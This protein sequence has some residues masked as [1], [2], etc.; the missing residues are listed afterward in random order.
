MFTIIRSGSEARFDLNGKVV[1]VCAKFN[2]YSDDRV[3]TYNVRYAHWTVKIEYD[4][5]SGR[6]ASF[7]YRQGS[8]IQGFDQYIDFADFAECIVMDARCGEGYDDFADFLDDFGY[9]P[10]DRDGRGRLAWDY[11]NEC[12][13]KLNRVFSFHRA[14]FIRQA[15]GRYWEGYDEKRIHN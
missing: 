4:G 6:A 1:R 14:D 3:G 7:K 11:C 2:N 5:K 10:D 8:G 9:D 15:E 12:V 13:R